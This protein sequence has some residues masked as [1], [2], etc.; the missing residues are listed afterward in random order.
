MEEDS[1]KLEI[2][3]SFIAEVIRIHFVILGQILTAFA[4]V[5]YPGKPKDVSEDIV[6]ITGAG[7]GIGRIIALRL[8]SS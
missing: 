5:I 1:V 7:A 4:K 8:E 3:L 2:M 6:L